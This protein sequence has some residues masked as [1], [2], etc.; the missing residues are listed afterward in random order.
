MGA[1]LPHDRRPGAR[2]QLRVVGGKIGAR[3]GDIEGRQ[4]VRF[5]L[6]ME[7]LFRGPPVLG[8]QAPLLTRF[9]VFPVEDAVRSLEE[10]VFC[11]AWSSISWL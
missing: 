8:P 3:H 4:A 2:A 10:P 6:D 11:S 7:E 9:V 5:V 1:Y